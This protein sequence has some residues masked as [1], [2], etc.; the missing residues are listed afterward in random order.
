[1][2][3]VFI[4]ISLT[5]L[6]CDSKLP[7]AVDLL[8]FLS[9][10]IFGVLIAARFDLPMQIYSIVIQVAVILSLFTSVTWRVRAH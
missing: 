1:M 7:S 8:V 6:K 2:L 3:L 4:L 9:I 5:P 10:S